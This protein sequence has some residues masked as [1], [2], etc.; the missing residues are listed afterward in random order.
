MNHESNLENK[1]QIN[2]FLLSL[3]ILG[4]LLTVSRPLFFTLCQERTDDSGQL[5]HT[6]DPIHAISFLLL[7]FSLL[8]LGLWGGQPH[9]FGKHRF[10]LVDIC[11]FCLV[12]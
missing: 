4:E 6:P 11:R 12:V 7:L 9:L 3:V 5:K 8:L 2:F 10:Y 1:N